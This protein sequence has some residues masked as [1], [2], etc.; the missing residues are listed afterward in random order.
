MKTISFGP[1]LLLALPSPEAW[2]LKT[3]NSPSHPSTPCHWT[4]FFFQLSCPSPCCLTNLFPRTSAPHPVSTLAQ[5]VRSVPFLSHCKP[6]GQSSALRFCP[7]LTMPGT[8]KKITLLSFSG[9]AAASC[10]HYV[11]LFSSAKK[12][13]GKQPS[14]AYQMCLVRI[15]C[16]LKPWHSTQYRQVLPLQLF[17]FSWLFWREA[18]GTS[19][20][21]KLGICECLA[22]PR[23]KFP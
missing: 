5:R 9:Q 10:L 7:T 21:L 15:S 12:H 6:N 19:L 23:P 14:L 17:E 3:P 18:R 16:D 1:Y 11:L 4:P 8:E 2:S 20:T 22:E 13:A